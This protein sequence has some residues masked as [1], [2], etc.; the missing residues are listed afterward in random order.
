MPSRISGSLPHFVALSLLFLT[1]STISG[2]AGG[3]LSPASSA[4]EN[5]A[6][7]D[8]NPLPSIASISPPSIVAESTDVTISIVGSGFVPGST[9]QWNGVTL[10]KTYISATSLSATIPGSMLASGTLTQ[11]VVVNPPPG[12]GSTAPVNLPVNNPVPVISQINPASFVAGSGDTALDINGTGF[13]TG[14]VIAWNATALPTTFVSAAEVKAT[15]PAANLTGSSQATITAQNFTPGGG[16]SSAVA[17]N[18]T[19]LTPAISSISPSIV[20]PIGP[21]TITIIGTGFQSNSTA[22]WNGS[23]RPTVVVSTTSLKVTLTA[24]D[25][26]NQ[27][28][29]SLSVNNP[30]PGASTSFSLPL[31]VT[32]QPFIQS[33]S[34]RSIVKFPNPCPQLQVTITGA[35]FTSNSTIQ[36]NGVS[37]PAVLNNNLSVLTNFL[38][39]TLVTAPGAL[40]FTV[41][42]PIQGGAVS[43]PFAYSASNPPLL[44][45]CVSP[46]PTTVF[47]GSSF[48]FTVQ[49]NG[50]NIGNNLT[51]ALGSL[52]TGVT[53][54]VTNASLPA[55]GTTLHLQA[56]PTTA[57]GNYDLTLTATAGPSPAAQGNFNFTVSSG[58]PPS[59]FFASS[60]QTEVGVPI[61]GSG[62]IRFQSLVNS[63]SGVD[64]DVTPSVT[65][66]PPGT[67]ASFSPSVFS[68]GQSVTV[69]LTAAGNAAVS[70]NTQVT[71]IGTPSVPVA[72]A[73]ATFLA[74]VTQPPGSLP[75]NRTDFVAT[76]ATPYAAV[77]DAAHNL[78]FA[79]N[80]DWNRVDVISNLTHKIVKSIPVHSPR[81][82]DITQDN[83]RVWV[84]T[85]SSSLYAVD[86]VSLTA[87]QY[88]LPPQTLGNTDNSLTPSYDRLLALADGT[89]FLIYSDPSHSG[90]GLDVGVW[91][92]QT[93]QL[94][95]LDNGL[96]GTFGFP[97][98]SGDGRFVYAA[99]QAGGTGVE[100][101]S[102]A[103]KSLTQ[104]GSG[105]VFN[106][107][108]AAN[109]D[110][111]KLI[112]AGLFTQA[113]RVYDANLNLLGSLPGT[114][115]GSAVFGADQKIYGLGVYNT[116]RGIV[117]I[118]SSSLQ[119][120]G[121]APLGWV[122]PVGTSGYDGTAKPFAVDS[123]GMVL[124]LQIFGIAFEDSAFY[125]QYAPNQTLPMAGTYIATYR[126]P[127]SGGTA[128][129]LFGS[130]TF[131]QPD[132]WFGQTRGT[133]SLSQGTVTFI[134]P[135]STTAGP[136]NVKFIFPDGGE[137]FYPQLFSYSTFPEYAL[138][139]GSS[140]QG[141]A[142]AQVL[143]YGLPQDPSEGTMSVG[144][145]SATITTVKGQYPPL[146]GEPYPS[147]IL[148]YIVPPGSPGWADINLNT[149]I[150]NGTLPKAM[151]YANS[152]TDYS[153]SD[154]FTAVVFD[155]GRNQVYLSAGDHVDVFSMAS[156]RFVTPLQ[157]AALGGQKKFTGLALTPDGSSLLAA[158]LADGSLAVINPDTPSGT[159]AILITT[160]HVGDN[161][162]PFGPL[163]VAATSTN[164]A[165]VTT[166]SLPAPSC[167]QSGDVFVANLLTRTATSAPAPPCFPGSLVT[168]A[169]GLS[170]DATAD[171]NFVAV[172]GPYNPWI[173]S[174]QSSS[175]TV[176]RFPESNGYGVTISGDGNVMGS[177]RD[178]FDSSMNL[179][180]Y[181]A[182]PPAL[183]YSGFFT[184]AN[185]PTPLLRPRLNA[186][187]SLYYF[188]Y[189]NYFEIIDVQHALLRMRFSLTETIQ[190]TAIPLAIDSGGRY[191]Y[192]IT[193][194]GL[195]V[196]DLGAA[197]LS[198][199]HLSQSTA[200]VGTQI[201]VRG[202]GFDSGTT[203]TVG[204]VPAPVTFTDE[205]TLTVTVPSASSGP[206]DLVLTRAGGE[207]YKLE[208]GIVI[209]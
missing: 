180:S 181:V 134:S 67:S 32:A 48:A 10:A 43:T 19:S 107:V 209:Q 108:T 12:G 22:L 24:S 188:S 146:S 207:S 145:N 206:Q 179:F 53:S 46:S 69:T 17:V 33:V 31:T 18:V 102:A 79:S 86:T 116:Y 150:G 189:P 130:A 192:L 27:G 56:A 25:L 169:Q 30:A 124:G 2:C 176:G 51:L 165:F 173:Y 142:P 103:T 135:P 197:P 23:P 203:A 120:L 101:Y 195:T 175:F 147:T 110:G 96:L 204:G 114:F 65:G 166:G 153:S 7:S 92:P 8:S 5:P 126:G 57:P 11:V 16:V 1:M 140:P 76:A 119:L 99:N 196:V 73:T 152:V 77:Y 109:S 4:P 202:S 85:A 131:L 115:S 200:P 154:S 132:V 91:D 139:S 106:Q 105:T 161:N 63:V 49:P 58:T 117:T 6:T 47:P 143:G 184:T 122:D 157:P 118:D 14:S 190:N 61:G 82:L 163:Y 9:V 72:N 104:L 80:S 178:L 66:L 68:A 187:G 78:I 193:D 198:D 38:P 29:G 90:N 95:A 162:C 94:T 136:V 100:V 81:G 60:Q 74:D 138:V 40:T 123:T 186:S 174:V 113:S 205:K 34:I 21:A 137:M 35:N 41:T 75:G 182:E 20:L 128:S 199:G 83:S 87:R 98:R 28:T 160:Q 111:S 183:Y 62:S 129:S 13:N 151:F 52:P 42:N 54:A 144:P 170:V 3:G 112:L 88:S 155:E 59:I 39:S 185:I 55:T 44:T 177:N 71:L 168:C 121:I 172:G 158:N 97:V 26:Q 36:A 37:L 167:P 89:L 164:Q 208:N 50:V 156:R 171:G 201:I 45:I 84:Q 93:D 141:G 127:L 64:I 194:K 70:E 191:V 159:Y 133:T 148:K 149:L 15:V 125:Q